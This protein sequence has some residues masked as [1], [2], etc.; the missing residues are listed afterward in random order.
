MYDQS[1]Q[2]V[3]SLA[4]DCFLTVLLGKLEKSFSSVHLLA[5]K[6]WGR[7]E[8]T[9]DLMNPVSGQDSTVSSK[10]CP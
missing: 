9:Q 5:G 2:D 3:A 4:S 6:A 1:S 7:S 8:K 10:L